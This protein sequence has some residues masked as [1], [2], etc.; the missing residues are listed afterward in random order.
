MARPFFSRERVSDFEVFGSHADAALSVISSLNSQGAPVEVQDLFARYTLDAAAESLF[1]EQLNSLKGDL[2]VP[3][4]TSMSAK[5]SLTGDDF[6]AFAQAFETAQQIIVTRTHKG[7]F[8]PLLQLFKDDVQPHADVIDK[9][10]EP[11]ISRVLEN[12]AQMRKAGLS[13]Q[14]QQST[15]LEYLAD[16]TEGEFL[17]CELT[18]HFTDCSGI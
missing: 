15:F 4:Q 17:R 3:G 6:G 9:W 8:W 7:Y 11:I 13:S 2:P 14:V 18:M 10:L 12:K 16:N 5:G 1:G